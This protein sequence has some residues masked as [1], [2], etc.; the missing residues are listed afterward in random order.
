MFERRLKIFLSI[1]LVFVLVLLARAMQLQVVDREF[2][3]NKASLSMRKEKPIETSRGRIM[4]FKGAVLAEDQPCIDACVDY[5]A[6]VD[7]PDPAW[8]TEQA[9][10]RVLEKYG[11]QYRSASSKQ[12]KAMMDDESAL[13]R[14]QIKLMWEK[15]SRL[16]GKPPGELDELRKSIRDRIEMRRRV[17][18]V[19]KWKGLQDRA[20]KTD[21]PWY[22]K[23]ILGEQPDVPEI[24]EIASE[25]ISDEQSAHVILEAIDHMVTPDGTSLQNEL[26]KH[27]DEYPA[28]KLMP[29]THRVYPYGAAACHVI[30]H[31]GKVQK[32]ELAK[33][34]LGDEPAPA[35]EPKVEDDLRGYRPNDTKGRDGLEALGEPTLRGARGVTV[36]DGI[37]GQIESTTPPIPGQDFVTTLDIDLQMQIQEM[38]THVTVPYDTDSRPWK[39]DTLPMHGAAVVMDVVTGDVRALVSSPDYDLNELDKQYRT[40]AADSN[41]ARPLM[42]RATQANF[43]PGSTVKPI[44]GAG[45]IT[46]RVLR[47]NEGIECTGYLMIGGKRITTS[48]KCW[49]VALGKAP[50]GRFH[51]SS[52]FPGLRR[53]RDTTEIPTG[54]SLIPMRWSARATSSSKRWPID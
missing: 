37:S 9:K 50:R 33:K 25:T 2:W 49:T 41:L 10:A 4:D 8:V 43:E 11:S 24:E 31:L 36:F 53:I 26:Q 23:W 22:R 18:A 20:S 17:V 3:A 16:S 21:P 5:R 42:N 47:V 19:R 29:N 45:A 48:N 44:V 38:F 39:W 14:S 28:L 30:G 46:D 6:I 35:D 12:R 27:A 40:L 54:F 15:L 13:F 34:E 32:E 1:L 7:P 52:S 51:A